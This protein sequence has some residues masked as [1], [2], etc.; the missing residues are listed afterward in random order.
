MISSA[1]LAFLTLTGAAD[2]VDITIDAAKVLHPMNPLYMGCH[3]D[4]GFVHEV[5][6][7]SSQ[8]LF[9]ESFERYAHQHTQRVPA[10][11]DR[12]PAQPAKHHDAGTVLICV[13]ARDR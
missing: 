6:G 7:W 12:Y 9:G 10:W 5:T 13:A 3:S 2:A 11:F 8:M 4:S 1:A